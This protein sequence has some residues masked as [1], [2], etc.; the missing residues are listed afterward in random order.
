MDGVGP[1]RASSLEALGACLRCAAKPIERRLTSCEIGP[2]M[3]KLGL[4]P[5]RLAQ[6]RVLLI[7]DLLDVLE[8]GDGVID[9]FGTEHD[10]E[11]VVGVAGFVE[12]SRSIGEVALRGDDRP[13]CQ[14]Q[15]RAHG[16]ALAF[17]PSF[18]FIQKRDPGPCSLEPSLD[19]VELEQG[20]TRAALE[21]SAMRAQ[22]GRALVAGRANHGRR[23]C[24]TDQYRRTGGERYQSQRLSACSHEARTVAQ[25]PQRERVFGA[26]G[27]LFKRPL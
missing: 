13:T 12:R 11:R 9:R 21:L 27:K 10:R 7:D 24:N 17:E 1:G 25:S 18:L 14:A 26:A 19:R 23:Q 16:S 4:C 22:R 8:A 20:V 6:N 5:S 2:Q 3:K 15:T